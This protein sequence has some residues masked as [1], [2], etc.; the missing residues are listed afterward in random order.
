MLFG[1]RIDFAGLHEAAQ[2]GVSFGDLG[3]AAPRH[4]TLAAGAERRAC[5]AK[6]LQ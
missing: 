1:E 3:I 6:L 2:F 4:P 5:A